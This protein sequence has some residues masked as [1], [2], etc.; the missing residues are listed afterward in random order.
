MIA[1][2]EFIKAFQF[3]IKN[4]PKR[5]ITTILG[6]F[7]LTALETISASM[8]LPLFSI[9]VDTATNTPLVQQVEKTLNSLGIPNDFYYLFGIFI[10][11]FSLKIIADLAIGIYVDNSLFLIAMDFRKKVISGLSNVSWSY[12][13]KQPQGIIVNTMIQEIRLAAGLFNAIKIIITSMSLAAL[14]LFLGAT[15]SWQ[16]LLIA[17]GLATFGALIARP[18]FT[19]SRR[20]G[21]RSIDSVRDISTNLLQGIRSY[22]TFKAMAREKELMQALLTSNKAYLESDLLEIKARKFLVASQEA[23]LIIAGILGVIF[24]RDILGIT[25]AEIGFMAIVLLR[26]HNNSKS[27]LQKFQ[28]I[29]KNQY[30]LNKYIEFSRDLLAHAE[31]NNGKREPPHPANIQFQ[32]VS[33]NHGK[34][35]ILNEINLFIPSTGLTVL[36]GPSGA[37]KSTIVDLLCGFYKPQKGKIIIGE[38]N[39]EHIDIYKWRNKIGYVSQDTYLLNQTLYD[40][41]AAFDETLSERFITEICHEAGLKNFLKHTPQGIKNIVGEGG[42]QISGGERQRIAI[43][44]A[45]AKNPEILIL[46]EPTSALD[47]K[48]EKNII[49]TIKKIS[50]KIPVL[51]ISHQTAFKL[52]ADNIYYLEN[53]KTKHQ[54]K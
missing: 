53:K 38:E 34:K 51:V 17:I 52:S 13:V 8:L 25:L 19:M 41:I 30:A 35:E 48:N 23:I 47:E 40:N 21:S 3:F 16:L 42:A 49:K 22:K 29:A 18:M 27:I 1:I 15:V 11:A 50:R 4:Y 32:N 39:L 54:Q 10:T 2:R 9:S 12:F 36:F 26:I 7:L 43:A 46:D 6:A 24:A 37:G 14:Y 5:M 44:R 20:S 28:T 33:F 31:K 45:L